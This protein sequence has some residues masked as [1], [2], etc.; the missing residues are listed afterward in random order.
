VNSVR[1]QATNAFLQKLK[2]AN[3]ANLDAFFNKKL[4]RRDTSE[5]VV[6]LSVIGY[7]LVFSYFTILKFNAFHAYAWDLGIFN[8]SLWT[9]LHSG[10]FFFSTV[11]QFIVP[12]GVFFGTHFSPI[13]YAV[14]P[15]YALTS[16]P[17][18]LLV[19][20]SFILA[21]GAVPLYFFAKN[22]LNNRVL[23]VV[24]SL[25]YLFYPPLQ[26][27]NW[28][29]FHVQAFLPLF[30][31]CTMYFLV[32]ERW[33]GYFL[34]VFLSLT[35]A[36]N[37]PI[38]VVF[39][40]LYGFWRFRTRI[41]NALKT[42]KLVD[43]VF[44]VPILTIVIA[45]A[46]LFFAGWIRQVNWPFNP[47]FLQLYKAVDHWPA[48]IGMDDPN[49]LPLYVIIQPGN[50][51]AALACDWPLKIL[52]M[53]LLF[54][55]L[56]FL[57]FGSS[58]T[59][60]SLAWLI[61]ALLSNYTPY[62]TIGAHFPVYP[63]AFIFLGAVEGLGSGLSIIGLWRQL[64]LRKISLSTGLPSLAKLVSKTKALLVVSLVFTIIISPLSPVM[65]YVG[66]NLPQF[67][68]YQPPMVT[69]HDELLQNISDLVIPSNASVL[70]QNSIFVHFSSRADAYVYPLPRRL[71][72]QKETALQTQVDGIFKLQEGNYS[73]LQTFMEGLFEFQGYNGTELQK[74]VEDL[75][76]KSQYVMVD[77][78]TDNYTATLILQR[79][80]TV[81]DFGL[82]AYSNV[83]DG[84][85]GKNIVPPQPIP[86]GTSLPASEEAKL[87]DLFYLSV[88]KTLYRYDG[89]P[90]D[91]VRVLDGIYLYEKNYF[92]QPDFYG[93]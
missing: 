10:K 6:Y 89:E 88:N 54:G 16:T 32:R 76:Q 92:E 86:S 36:E 9:T 61:P 7:T 60:I 8:Q 71:S 3:F 82:V 91:W 22:S 33:P 30:F 13:L 66:K 21:L 18:A 78:T 15:F 62:Y 35:V 63:V 17:Q 57:S 59:A 79:M 56:L 85:E 53:F 70:T 73:E 72:G 14:L 43:A 26:G 90:W 52:Y 83:T 68:D 87:G 38:T 11:E 37:V 75:F 20:Q 23:A 47:A 40:G 93:S 45:V 67:A 80:L 24:F 28:F 34:F 1:R 29:D 74:Y 41:V 39:I 5:I 55:P 58:M 31:F 81:K 49:R 65:I 42:R 25:A 46:W 84:T 44:L 77:A 50:A 4:L 51:V 69:R 2:Q 48:F 27:A 19:I 12:S 64:R